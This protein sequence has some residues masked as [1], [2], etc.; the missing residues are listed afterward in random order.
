MTDSSSTKIVH[1]R[2]ETGPVTLFMFPG[3][4][5]TPMAMYALA[6]SIEPAV[7]VRGVLYSGI[8]DDNDPDETVTDMARECARRITELQ[9]TG[10]YLLCGYC[11]GGLVAIEAAR[12][13]TEQGHDVQRVILLETVS[14]LR[15]LT[16]TDAMAD[17]AEDRI[18]LSEL[19]HRNEA[20]FLKVMVAMVVGADQKM[21]NLSDTSESRIW[22]AT[23]K[24]TLAGINY[25]GASIDVPITVLHTGLEVGDLFDLWSI[26]TSKEVKRTVVPG[27]TL[28]MLMPPH[29]QVLGRQLGLEI[30][31]K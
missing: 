7:S 11:F 19:K 9:S 2:Q 18:T 29:V 14:P 17:S 5:A 4:A 21:T 20:H 24:H 23:E 31:R 26:F 27:D 10:P 8:A 16:D 1:L 22:K 13:L 6:H 30:D 3:A 15:S 25:R 12:I 28:T